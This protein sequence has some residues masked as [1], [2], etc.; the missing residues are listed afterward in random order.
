MNK[1]IPNA[2]KTILDN[3]LRLICEEIPAVRSVC[4]GILIGTGSGNEEKSESGLSHFIEHMSFR[5]TSKRSA[6][7]IA[8]ALDTVGGK[9]NAFTSK[10]VTVFYCV[11]L[12][13]H[14]PIAIDILSD[15]LLNSLYDEKFLTLEKQVVLEEIKM[16]EDTPNEQ[17]HDFFDEKI[18][19]GHPIGRPTIGLA[20]TV[21]SFKRSN[22]LEFQK[23]WYQ[24]NNAIVSIAG[25]TSP[26]IIKQLSQAFGRWQGQTSLP[27]L[28]L[29]EIKGSLNLRQKKTE[30]VHLCLG[31]K[32]VSQVDGERYTYAVLDNILGG[33]MS[34]HLFQEI[35]EKRG[36]AYS[37]YSTSSPFRNFGVAYVYAGTSKDNMA[38]VVDLILSE[39][40]R[41]KKNGITAAELERA[42]EFIKGTLVLGLE[43][44][45]SRMSWLAKSEFYHNRVTTVDDIF[46]KVDKVTQED[47]LHIADKFFRDEYL[48]LAVIGDMKKLPIKSLSCN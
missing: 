47:I 36:L 24:P 5:G 18:L 48:T 38:Q 3:G 14:V 7:D 1:T 6:Y 10:E 35:R 17:V 16:Y 41:L 22:I 30:Q 8:H 23:K 19:R 44:T 42:K 46:A 15:I 21:S 13:Q 34:S 45:S 40:R 33:S 20:K 43:S 26:D 25:A 32:G 4:L 37:I 2:S 28:Q 27:P 39:F 29:P 31:V 9:I 12:D 11:V